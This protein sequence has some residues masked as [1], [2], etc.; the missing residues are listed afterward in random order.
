MSWVLFIMWGLRSS[1]G[2]EIWQFQV[3]MVIFWHV[4]VVAQPLPRKWLRALPSVP[5]PSHWTPSKRWSPVF[6]IVLHFLEHSLLE[7]TFSLS[8][9]FV[10]Q[11]CGCMYYYYYLL[12]SILFGYRFILIH[13]PI[14]GHL[15]SFQFMHKS[16]HR[17]M[18]SFHLRSI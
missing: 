16:L 3:Y 9:V 14:N 5:T 11:S 4:Y 17:H 1:V 13:L 7:L 18:F 8:N 6:I 10:V 2:N 15:E 12:S